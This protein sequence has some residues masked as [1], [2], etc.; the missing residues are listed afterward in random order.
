MKRNREGGE[1]G[2]GGEDNWQRGTGRRGGRETGRDVKTNTQ[3]NPKHLK[4]K[5]DC[6]KY[7][8]PIVLTKLKILHSMVPD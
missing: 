8:G 1:D 5:N 4:S 3:K 6:Y 2:G 7:K